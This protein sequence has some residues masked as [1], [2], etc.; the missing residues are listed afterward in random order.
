MQKHTRP[1]GN[2]LSYY[3]LFATAFLATRA[4]DAQVTD[5]YYIDFDP[6]LTT[7]FNGVEVG[8]DAN[9][10]GYFDFYMR[11]SQGSTTATYSGNVVTYSGAIAWF[12]G[13]VDLNVPIAG[14][15]YVDQMYEGQPMYA[16]S[17]ADSFT[18]EGV[19]GYVLYF[20]GR[21]FL[22]GS[23][24]YHSNGGLWDVDGESA[25]IGLK[26]NTVT[27]GYAW[28]RLAIDLPDGIVA[29]GTSF[30]VLTVT[31]LAYILD[32]NPYG[33]HAGDTEFV[34]VNDFFPDDIKVYV[35]NGILFLNDEHGNYLN[36]DISL[37]AINGDKVLGQTLENNQTQ[38]DISNLSKGIYSILL[39]LQDK[40]F[41]TNLHVN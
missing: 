1:Q 41:A 32:N 6:D 23:L 36:S 40:K 12:R 13:A 24:Q 3:S 5:I 35:S 14:G 39:T 38:I 8:I 4:G 27:P 37:F 9:D 30:P 16:G 28:L 22:N 34:G 31:E 19:W 29:G 25:L 21:T 15:D 2:K 7:T 10:D 17:F 26:F 33:F 11:G 20:Y 18:A